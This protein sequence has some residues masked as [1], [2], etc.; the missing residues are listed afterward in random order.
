MK[1]KIYEGIAASPG[2]I[3]G[4]AF[5]FDTEEVSVVPHPV[6]KRE[7]PEEIARFEDALIATR[8][9]LL[10][11]RQQL[12]RRLKRS[13]TDLFNAHLL[14]VEDRTL[15]EEVIRGIEDKHLNAEYVFQ[16]VIS[17][18]EQAFSQIKD[19]YLKERIKDIQDVARRV[20][21]NLTGRKRQDL[22]RLEEEVIVIAP[23][24]SPS[25]T[26]LMHKEKVIGFAT[27]VG[28]RTSHTAIMAR[29]LA[30]PAVVGLKKVSAEVRNGDLVVVDGNKGLFIVNPSRTTLNR[31][32]REQKRITEF[33]KKLQILRD[34]PA[35][36]ADGF[37]VTLAANIEMPEDLP[38]VISHGAQGVGL[39]R[40]EF[41]YLNRDD[42]PSEEEQFGAYNEVA[43]KLKPQS[44]II[45]TLDLGGDKFNSSLRMPPEIN[46][47][48]GCRA[49]RFCLERPDIF[50]T[51]LRAI[52]RASRNKNVKVMFPMISG[53]SELN[54]ILEIWEEEK[55]G[56]KKEGIP[57][58]PQMEVGIMIEVPS[59]VVVA[60]ILA[61]EVDFFSFG[62]NDLIQY[63][64][65]VDR[66]NEKIAY[67]Y[68][69]L[70]P[71]ILRSLHQVIEV[72]HNNNIWVGMCG[73]MAG[74]PLAIPLLLG[75]GLDEV[76]VSPAMVP[77]VKK[78]IRSL[79][80]AEVRELTRRLLNY[81]SAV[82]IDREVRKALRGVEGITL[83][84]PVE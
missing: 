35:E 11:I 6:E 30:I 7:V 61:E 34:L 70:H 20:L 53:Y 72:A 51:H 82:E 83:P 39:Y 63:T 18:Y 12:A 47:F 81:R 76:S 42:L 67:L 5:L 55:S 10:R 80:L 56:L 71:A 69:P 22:A 23:D 57:F 29:S 2:L 37:R 46:P 1:E 28:G 79:K 50:R 15:I 27:D 44:V 62:T 25:D 45:R 8:R 36:T 13:E 74:D 59:A 16:Q 78:I 19:D 9:E 58:D 66:V 26:A 60:D 3:E 21:S 64:L 84:P 41:F 31:I 14:V 43:K 48:L 38:S 52:L 33:E 73:E 17:R 68:N 24:L 65:A 32:H 75:M 4:K 40:T 49:V 77:E 54:R